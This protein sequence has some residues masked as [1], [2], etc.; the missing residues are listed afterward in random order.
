MGQTFNIILLV[1]G[2]FEILIA[3]KMDK[4]TMN[5]YKGKNIK[6]MNGL[7][8]WEKIVAIST[9]IVIIIFA[10][11]GLLSLESYIQN[12]F[13]III[14]ILMVVGAVHRRKFFVKK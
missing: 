5:K 3:F 11:M 7:I 12:Y 9:G 4:I 2:C 1:L 8:K 14:I 6:D 10:V 13:I